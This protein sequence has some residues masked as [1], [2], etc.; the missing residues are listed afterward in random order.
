MKNR[1]WFTLIELI[2][3]IT[4]IVLLTMS[5]YIPYSYYQNKAKLKITSREITQALYEARNMAINWSINNIW[6]V[7]IWVYFDTS[8]SSLN[9][10]KIY[11]Y[12]FDIETNQ[13]SIIEWWN[14]ELIKTIKL[15]NWI[16]LENITSKDNVLFYFE[17]ITWKLISYTW[18]SWIKTPILDN[19][20]PITFSYK[21]STSPNLRKTINY[22]TNTNIIDY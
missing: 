7:S 1:K 3:S 11:S 10:I 12:T 2:I 20:M 21:W 13:I 18:N 6:N 19:V 17:S 5:T 4:I 22:F 14:V 9:E 15:Q 8:I 16:Q